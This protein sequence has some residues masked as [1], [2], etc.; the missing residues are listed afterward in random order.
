MTVAGADRPL[1]AK[2]IGVHFNTL[3]KHYSAELEL[4]TAQKNAKV[5]QSLYQ[6]ALGGN[7]AAQIFWLKTRAR[8][9]EVARDEVE[10]DIDDPNTEL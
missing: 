8:W 9:R 1:I 3:S 6:N 2:C 5:A 7:V 4:S 10:P